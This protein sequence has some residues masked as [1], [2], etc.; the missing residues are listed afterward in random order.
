M[1]QVV[2]VSQVVNSVDRCLQSPLLESS[3]ANHFVVNEDCGDTESH[4]VCTFTLNAATL[5]D[6][7]RKY[8]I[9][10]MNAIGDFTET[11]EGKNILTVF[12]TP[13]LHSVRVPAL[14]IHEDTRVE[15]L[16][17]NIPENYLFTCKFSK[18]FG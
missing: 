1:F 3:V 8:K 13:A 2:R 17:S 12:K 4:Y 18:K 15:I 14:P 10:M 6:S 16:G 7:P 11:K 9:Q 5:D